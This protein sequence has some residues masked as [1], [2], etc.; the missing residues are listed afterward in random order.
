MSRATRTT[1]VAK[2]GLGNVKM[3]ASTNAAGNKRGR[4]RLS[5]AGG[6]IR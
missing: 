6:S 2:N 4:D 5:K 3:N 1:T